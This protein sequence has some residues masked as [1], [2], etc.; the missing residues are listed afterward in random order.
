MVYVAFAACCLIW[1]STFLAIRLG[2]EAVP[3]VW[4]AAIRLVLAAVALSV[5]ARVTGARFPR[6]AA[7]RGAAL[8]GFFNF[9]VN[10][11]LL[12]IGEN[13]IPSG[14]AAI[15]FAT[16]PLSTGLI[17]W[18]LH[19]EPLAPRKLVAAVAAVVGIVTIFAGELGLAV[20][21]GGL[22]TVLVAATSAALSG[23]LLK[24]APRQPA[25]P[26]NAV[27]AAVG[28]VVCLATSVALG[29][30]HALPA[31][32]EGW[33]PILY[34]TVAGSLG[35]FVLFAW[36]IKTW[37]V[38]NASFIGVVAPIVAVILGAIVRQERPALVA[39]LGA[40]IVIGAVV[41]ALW[42]SRGPA[43]ALVPDAT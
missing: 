9:G 32:A 12:Y 43:P 29:E 25:I 21:L 26:A 33:A 28:A 35:A 30:D 19:V 40:V 1:G 37:S 36:L 41:F 42:P 15:L 20:P 13:S 34:L 38:T 22:L 3:P 17:A 18:R 16:V 31:T 10:F 5:I 8:F 6:G 11:V 2:N 4:A 27:A 14:I 39:L 7:L 23:V 24:Q